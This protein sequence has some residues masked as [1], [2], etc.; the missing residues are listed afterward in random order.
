MDKRRDGRPHGVAEACLLIGI[1]D[2]LEAASNDAADV[3][4][5]IL[6][7]PPDEHAENLAE[8][9]VGAGAV[10]PDQGIRNGCGNAP[11]H[12]YSGSEG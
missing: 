10:E 2:V 1:G 12:E 6:I 8:I 3:V 7:G 11:H 5:Q 9:A 4:D